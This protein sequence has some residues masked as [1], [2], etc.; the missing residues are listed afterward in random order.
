MVIS[1]I[2]A[3]MEEKTTSL[4]VQRQSRAIK[5]S[6]SPFHVTRALSPLIVAGKLYDKATVKRPLPKQVIRLAKGIYLTL[7]FLFII[8][9]QLVWEECHYS[10]YAR[11]ESAD[12]DMFRSCKWIKN[13]SESRILITNRNSVQSVTSFHYTARKITFSETRESQVVLHSI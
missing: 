2:L 9:S 13:R 1:P 4:L 10:S 5:G 3:R 7:A 11:I 6:L 12:T 8:T